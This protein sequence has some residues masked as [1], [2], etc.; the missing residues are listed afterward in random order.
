MRRGLRAE[1]TTVESDHHRNLD[2]LH[3]RKRARQ[4]LSFINNVAVGLD[5]S[6]S[7]RSD[8]SSALVR[9]PVQEIKCYTS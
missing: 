8:Q 1:V 9:T 6:G 3:A 5:F 7:N 4:Y 2:I